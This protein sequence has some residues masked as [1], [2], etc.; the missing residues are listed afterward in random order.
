MFGATLQ[1]VFRLEVGFFVA[2]G[3]TSFAIKFDMGLFLRRN[4]S[5]QKMAFYGIKFQSTVIFLS[6]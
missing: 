6:L 4:A 5:Y 2:N 1:L 3:E